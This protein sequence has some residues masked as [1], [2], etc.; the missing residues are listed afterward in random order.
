MPSFSWYN[1]LTLLRLFENC[2]GQYDKAG[3]LM[4]PWCYVQGKAGMTMYKQFEK[5]R[6]KGDFSLLPELHVILS[7]MKVC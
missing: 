6:N 2:S 5:A 7:G 4:R 3:D 1:P